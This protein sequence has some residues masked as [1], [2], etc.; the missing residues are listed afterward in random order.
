MRPHSVYTFVLQRATA[1]VG[2][3]RALANYVGVSRSRLRL[4]LQHDSVP[5]EVFL[6]LVDLLLDHSLHLLQVD[7][8]RD[9]TTSR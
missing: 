7:A 2:G 3:E 6:K 1:L 8:K 5:P 9:Q 4:W